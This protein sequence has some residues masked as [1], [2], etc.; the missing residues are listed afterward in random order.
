M[1]FFLGILSTLVITS[2]FWSIYQIKCSIAK[3]AMAQAEQDLLKGDIRKAM[4]GANL[5]LAPHFS[6]LTVFDQNHVPLFSVPPI[7]PEH[8]FLASFEFEIKPQGFQTTVGSARFFFDISKAI[9]GAC[10]F[11]AIVF[12]I[13]YFLSVR[14][15]KNLLQRHF[16]AIQS[17]RSNALLELAT[18][19]SHD[20][21]SP[22]SAINM[23]I[24][25]IGSIP[26]DRRDLIQSSI[27]RI[28][29]IANDL[30]N[31]Y[32]G[33]NYLPTEHPSPKNEV[34]T[35]P[36]FIAGLLSEI[37]NEKKMIFSDRKKVELRLDLKGPENATCAV[38]PKEISRALSN[39]INNAVEALGPNGGTVTLALRSAQTSVAIIVSDDGKGIPENVLVRLGNEKISFGKNSTESGSGIGVFH[40]KHAVTSMGG[41]F[42]IQSRVGIGTI[43]TISFPRSDVELKHGAL[44]S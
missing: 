30:L 4:I 44:T 29:A 23:A 20:I 15:K 8:K 22:L 5:S 10:C 19:V 25:G 33:P 34:S 7:V 14:A 41:K 28:N 37:Y 26:D 24:N 1:G 27:Q 39:L 16:E 18:Q 38:D 43:V 17:E 9:F 35:N 6:Y 11:L 12:L 40:A 32:R 31:Q 21:R 42:T 2:G 3:I 36:T 13:F